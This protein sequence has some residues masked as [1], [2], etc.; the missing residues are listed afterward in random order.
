MLD[1]IRVLSFTHFVQ[2][3]AAAQHLAD[4]G[5]DVVK[6]EPPGGA[7]ERRTGSGG[8][9]VAGTSVTFLAVNRNCRAIAVD[10]KH[11]MAAEVLA[12]LIAGADVVL[13]NYRPGALDKL[14]FGYEAVRAI[15]PDIVYASATGWGGR[16]PMGER[17]GVDVLVQARSGLI[18]ATGDGTTAAGSPVVDHHGAALLALGVLAALV[19]RA[20]TGEGARVEASLLGAGLDLQAEAIALFHGGRR[21]RADLRRDRH[22]AAWFIDAPYGVYRL[23]DAVAVIAL[24]GDMAGFVSAIGAPALVALGDE[25]RL[26]DRDAFTAALA[27][28][29]AGWTWERL[30]AALG[31]RGFWY[32]RVAD[33]ADLPA[34]PQVQAEG[35]LTEVRLRDEPVTLVRHPVRYDGELPPVR[36]MPPELGEHTR[37]VLAESGVD[38]E[39]IDAWFAAGAVA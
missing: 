15:R 29:L 18:A 27:A 19:R 34:D 2:G 25:G 8:I 16:G 32:E 30:D 1:R 36:R 20:R 14:G 37:E 35:L 23:A 26:T 22:L 39:R 7:W 3:P 24:S 31:P 33:Y 10:L 12:P 13:E 9:R 17:P 4:L 21:T 28:E 5:A 11:P 6:I 38:A